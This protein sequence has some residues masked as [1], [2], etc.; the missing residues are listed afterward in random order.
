[1]LF[2]LKNVWVV[3]HFNVLGAAFFFFCGEILPDFDLKWAAPP[4][5]PEKKL[6]LGQI[7]Q[8]ARPNGG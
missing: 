5:K 1:V 4:F 7:H 8:K 2:Y 3:L 6:F